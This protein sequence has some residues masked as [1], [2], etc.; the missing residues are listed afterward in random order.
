MVGQGRDGFVGRMRALVLKRG[1]KHRWP[2]RLAS[3]AIRSPRASS[4][5]FVY[6]YDFHSK[7]LPRLAATKQD[8][9]GTTA[10][11][12]VRCHHDDECYRNPKRPRRHR[13]RRH[14]RRTRQRARTGDSGTGRQSVPA[15]FAQSDRR[16]AID[17]LLAQ[18]VRS[19]KPVQRIRP[20]FRA[21]RRLRTLCRT[22]RSSAGLYW[23][24]R[25]SCADTIASSVSRE[26]PSSSTA[27]PTFAPNNC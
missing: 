19:P 1:W 7:Q 15:L 8:S 18:S 12:S 5:S 25:S 2:P 26:S 22:E 17:A 23:T 6:V 10:P 27:R 13:S 3:W 20:D 11:F 24:G 21:Q 16:R 9:D 14:A 4:E